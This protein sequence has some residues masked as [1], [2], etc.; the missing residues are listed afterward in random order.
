MVT[1]P[2][3]RATAR[4]PLPATGF[5]AALRGGGP[6]RGGMERLSPLRQAKA[7]QHDGKPDELRDAGHDAER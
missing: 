7:D 6:S 5:P 1:R 2:S 3:H 4:S